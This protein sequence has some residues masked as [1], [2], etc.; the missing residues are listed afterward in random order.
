MA[1]Q[2]TEGQFAQVNCL[3]LEG[4]DGPLIEC[5]QFVVGERS[6][7]WVQ[8][9]HPI[10][11]DVVLELQAGEGVHGLGIKF[12]GSQALPALEKASDGCQVVV[13]GRLFQS[14]SIVQDG[15]FREVA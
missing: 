6:L 14:G 13:L 12:S 9:L 2:E 10:A 15:F 7:Q 5:C 4:D 8:T 1:A 3:I 11:L